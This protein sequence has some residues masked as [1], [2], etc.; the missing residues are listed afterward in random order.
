MR[1]REAEKSRWLRDE[2]HATMQALGRID[3]KLTRGELALMREAGHA[4]IASSNH[5]GRDGGS[6]HGNPT[7]GIGARSGVTSAAV[8]GLVDG[9]SSATSSRI[10]K[11]PPH[12]PATASLP[13]TPSAAPFVPHFGPAAVASAGSGGVRAASSGLPPRGMA[14]R[15]AS[16]PLAGAIAVGKG[17][18][19]G[20]PHRHHADR[21][22]KS[23]APRGGRMM[24]SPSTKE[25]PG[26]L[27]P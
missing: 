6:S 12:M 7:G 14:A 3:T 25:H 1:R 2:A 8:R 9:D 21:R 15:F 24:P 10:G 11:A 13:N 20:P 22:S 16:S 5:G 4:G 26:V 18:P 27:E 19:G 23:Q 17:A